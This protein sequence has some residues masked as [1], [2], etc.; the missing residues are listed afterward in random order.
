MNV[1]IDF[2]SRVFQKYCILVTRKQLPRHVRITDAALALQYECPISL[3]T[4]YQPITVLGSDPRHTFSAP[5]LDELTKTSKFDPLNDTPLE[6]DWRVVDFAVDKKMSS[7]L[8]CI[9]L[10]YGG[11]KNTKLL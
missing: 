4:L 6:A 8:A 3:S 1:I 9:P 7:A 10:T 5:I 11:K 2:L